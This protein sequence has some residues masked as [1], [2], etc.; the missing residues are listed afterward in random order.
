MI[1]ISSKNIFSLFIN[2]LILMMNSFCN[3]AGIKVK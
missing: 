2:D 3:I 1:L